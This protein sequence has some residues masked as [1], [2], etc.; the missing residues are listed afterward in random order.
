[1]NERMKKI[2][3]TGGPGTGKTTLIESLKAQEFH[4]LPEIS[5]QVTLEAREQGIEQLFLTD[6]L[7][8]SRKLMEGRVRQYLDSLNTGNELVFF[9][10]GI[11]DV[12]A[13]MDYIGDVYPDEFVRTC[14]KHPYDQIF[15]L[16][17]WEDIYISDNER[18]E[19]FDQAR[20]IHDHLLRTYEN[21]GYELLEV[22]TG[23]PDIR[24][25]FIIN[26]LHH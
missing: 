12:L 26:N 25:D 22:P 18:Y 19:N 24:R 23:T 21:F 7:L 13:Y 3:V 16:P 5:R 11:P 17:P 20:R 9:D 4:C 1:M 10:R 2:V 6:P 15:L 14:E 8:F